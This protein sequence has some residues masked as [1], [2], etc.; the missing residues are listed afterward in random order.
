MNYK[1]RPSWLATPILLAFSMG[2]NAA[3]IDLFTVSDFANDVVNG[4]TG[5]SSQVS[6]A[7]IPSSILGGQRDINANAISNAVDGSVIGV[8]DGGD[9]CSR[10][11]IS[12][13]NLTVSN[14][15]TVIGV[16]TVQWDGADA[17][18]IRDTGLVA[19][20]L[21]GID[22]RTDG[23]NAVTF[24]VLAADLGFNFIVEVYTNA[25]AF[26]KVE[27]PSAGGPLTRTIQFAAFENAGFCGNPPPGI[28]SFTCGTGNTVPVNMSNLGA[29][30]LV[31]NTTQPGT[32]AVDLRIGPIT[33][34][35]EPGV[36]G[37]MGVGLFLTGFAAIR[38]RRETKTN[39]A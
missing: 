31:I 20:G 11:T 5:T 33:T 16:T 4:G 35:P 34:I 32:A 19:T 12:G 38:R 28:V 24:E 39:E 6:D 25:G 7:A 15:G 23:S 30:Q 18:A 37:L 1:L 9:Q 2:A 13:G 27:I 22:L 3:T 29:I 26:S 21:G 17:S 10:V 36:L 8:C 14:D